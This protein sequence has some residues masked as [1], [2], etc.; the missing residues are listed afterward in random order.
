MVFAVVNKKAVIMK[1]IV[2]LLLVI[3]TIAAIWGA[4][5]MV[6]LTVFMI[7]SLQ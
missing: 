5:S 3:G 6:D 7:C 1:V 4:G 2:S